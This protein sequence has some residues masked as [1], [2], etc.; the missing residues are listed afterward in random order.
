MKGIRIVGLAVHI[1]SQLT[2]IAPYRAAF[3][4]IA[5]LA[6]TLRKAGLPVERID[7]GGGI[8]ISYRGEKTIGIDDYAGLVREI[9]APLGTAIEIE[10][11]R[12]IVGAA[13]LLVSRVI[14][15]K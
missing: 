3:L 9:I 7:L 4:K 13:G 15:V 1:G 10:P 5:E 14:N 6:T 2:D 11:G 8:G 12:S